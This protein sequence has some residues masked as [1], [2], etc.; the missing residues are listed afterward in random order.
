MIMK[1]AVKMYLFEKG[2][3]YLAVV[4]M[5]KKGRMCIKIII[6]GMFQ[7]KNPVFFKKL[8]TNN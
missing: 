7:D 1:T 8:V 4:S 5:F 6:S 2:E 3:I